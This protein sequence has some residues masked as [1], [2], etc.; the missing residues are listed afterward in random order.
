AAA[1]TV[2]PIAKPVQLQATPIVR[3]RFGVQVAAF[4]TRQRAEIVKRD[5]E[6]K[7]SYMAYLVPANNRP[8][9]KVVVGSYAD[10]QSVDKVRDDL[11]QNFGYA[12]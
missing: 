11:R 9:V 4:K 8:L 2:Q 12:D 3:T 5:L 10:R 1:A 7:S 6:A